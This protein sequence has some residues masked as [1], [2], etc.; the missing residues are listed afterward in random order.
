MSIN[1]LDELKEI[2][3]KHQRSLNKSK[4]IYLIDQDFLKNDYE[5]DS[6]DQFFDG[7]KTVYETE[8]DG[9]IYGSAFKKTSPRSSNDRNNESSLGDTAKRCNVSIRTSK[10]K[11]EASVKTRMGNNSLV[12][13]KLYTVSTDQAQY[14]NAI[15]HYQ[16][17]VERARKFRQLQQTKASHK[18]QRFLAKGNNPVVVESDEPDRDRPGTSVKTIRMPIKEMQAS[19]D[20]ETSYLDEDVEFNDKIFGKHISHD[21]KKHVEGKEFMSNFE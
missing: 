15:N 14:T 1:S 4:H 11:A 17:H 9:I 18:C 20:W 13:N 7:T 12:V 2:Q 3:E 5:D 21:K 16:D 19:K 10:G 6:S 8:N